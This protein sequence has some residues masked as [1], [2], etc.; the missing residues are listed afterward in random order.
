M[1][2]EI[3]GQMIAKLPKWAQVH[4]KELARERDTAIRALNEYV[5]GQNE[6]P[7]F[8]EDLVSTGEERGPSLKRVY[9]QSRNVEIVFGGLHLQVYLRDTIELR[10]EDITRGMSH[11][12][13]VPTSLNGASLYSKDNMR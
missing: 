8:Y 12:A 7:I 6:S 4:I 13:F 3:T 11:V 9:V 1:K 5:D 10:W 2:Q